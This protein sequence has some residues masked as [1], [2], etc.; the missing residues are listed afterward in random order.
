MSAPE[1]YARIAGAFV[2]VAII[3]FGCG[4]FCSSEIHKH[5]KAKEDSKLG[6]RL[7]KRLIPH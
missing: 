5:R 1:L 4:F 2:V 7:R 3:C 6:N